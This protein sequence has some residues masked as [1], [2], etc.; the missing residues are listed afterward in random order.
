MEFGIYVC[1]NECLC[2]DLNLCDMFVN[3]IMWI[4]YMYDSITL[5]QPHFGLNVRM[6][7]TFPKMGTWNLSGLLKIQ[8]LIVG[9]KTPPIGVFF[10]LMDRSWSVNV[11]NGLAWA[12]WTFVAQVVGKR[13]AGSQTGNLTPDH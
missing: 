12:I 13:R 9:V 1:M 11:Q 4:V 3:V 2:M 6:K 10:I 7:L 8:S 5:S